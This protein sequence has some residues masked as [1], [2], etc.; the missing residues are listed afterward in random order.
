M[1]M[2]VENIEKNLARIHE[3][4]KAVDQKINTILAFQGVLI[5]LLFPLIFKWF[6][7][8]IH[9]FDSFE[10]ILLPVG[11]VFLLEGVY[12]SFSA[13]I[14][15]ISNNAENKSLTFFAHISSESVEQYKKRV[16]DATDDHI[17][18]DLIAQT[19]VSAGIANTKHVELRKS[20][21]RFVIGISILAI[22]YIEFAIRKML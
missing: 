3:W 15:R 6:W 8:N 1:T 17:L 4:I 9:R 18:D 5:V 16:G 10:I 14:P 11:V 22:V 12:R 20:M 13:V 7:K 2:K 19:H 21:I